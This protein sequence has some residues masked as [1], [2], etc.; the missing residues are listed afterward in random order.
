[1]KQNIPMV[2]L[3]SCLI[4]QL[5]YFVLCFGMAHAALEGACLISFGLLLLYRLRFFTVRLP[6]FLLVIL[7]VMGMGYEGLMYVLHVYQYAQPLPNSMTVV[8][9]MLLW[10]HFIVSFPYIMAWLRSSTLRQ[11]V[12]GLCFGYVGYLFAS[13]IGV[14]VMIKP[15]WWTACSWALILPTLTGMQDHFLVNQNNN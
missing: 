11:V 12:L 14:I 13:K 1:M 3:L 15:L 9:L 4:F 7:L 5:S 6:F 10:L 8:W 2:S